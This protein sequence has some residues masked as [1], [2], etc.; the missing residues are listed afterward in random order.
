MTHF[1]KERTPSRFSCQVTAESNMSSVSPS[2]TTGPIAITTAAAAAI[3]TDSFDDCCSSSCSRTLFPRPAACDQYDDASTSRHH[4]A[5]PNVAV[6]GEV[7]AGGLYTAC[8]A[9]S[10]VRQIASL[11]VPAASPSRC[12]EVYAYIVVSGLACRFKSRSK[13]CCI[14]VHNT[15]DC[16]PMP[17]A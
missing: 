8:C 7:V 15:G 13:H 1:R 3:G 5:D 14:L 4:A 12:V 9:C 11:L 2:L 16:Y 17:N 10:A 6:A